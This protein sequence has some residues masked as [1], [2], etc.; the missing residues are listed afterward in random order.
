MFFTLV[1]IISNAS[2]LNVQEVLSL[3]DDYIIREK[4]VALYPQVVMALCS[5]IKGAGKHH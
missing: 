2:T 4:E 1:C 5:A 3:L